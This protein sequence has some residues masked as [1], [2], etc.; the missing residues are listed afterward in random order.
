VLLRARALE[1]LAYVLAPAQIGHHG[2]GRDSF[3]DA[4]IVD[5]WGAVVARVAD[6][7]DVA[8]AELDFTRLERLRRELPALSHV[9]VPVGEVDARRD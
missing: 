2:P 7:E 3:G 4:M 5:P 9:R 6:G 1:N 8:L